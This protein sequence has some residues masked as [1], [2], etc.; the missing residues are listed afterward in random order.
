MVWAGLDP[1]DPP[2]PSLA[3]FIDKIEDSW[4]SNNA[5]PVTPSLTAPGGL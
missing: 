2:I 4:F 3:P 1:K 5:G